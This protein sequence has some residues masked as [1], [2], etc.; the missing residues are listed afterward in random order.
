MQRAIGGVRRK[1]NRRLSKQMKRLSEMA[2]GYRK[3][4]KLLRKLHR[5]DLAEQLG[6]QEPP[7]RATNPLKYRCAREA[8]FLMDRWSAKAATFS[9]GGPY[10]VVAQ[11]LYEAATGQRDANIKRACDWTLHQRRDG[12]P[13]H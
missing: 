1:P 3:A 13:Q 8:Y 9:A 11:K 4:A 2:A 12:L 6:R 7:P 5:A 10:Q